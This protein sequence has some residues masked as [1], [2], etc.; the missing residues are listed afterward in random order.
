MI[1]GNTKTK[2]NVCQTNRT[3]N[4]LLGDGVARLALDDIS[5]IPDIN[6]IP[7]PSSIYKKSDIFMSFMTQILI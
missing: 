5:H 3:N 2:G 4:A 7:H 1:L 6:D